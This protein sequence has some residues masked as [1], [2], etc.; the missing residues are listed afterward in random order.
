L[1]PGPI[2]DQTINTG[3]TVTTGPA[4]RTVRSW[5]GIVE[6]IVPLDTV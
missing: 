4:R 3:S 2:A 6:F 5:Y 1:N